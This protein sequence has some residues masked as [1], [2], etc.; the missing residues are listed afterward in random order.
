MAAG[1]HSSGTRQVPYMPMT[2]QAIPCPAPILQDD[3]DSCRIPG[4]VD[5][6]SNGGFYSPGECFVGYR[7]MCTQ[8]AAVSNGWPIQ[9][10]E[11]VVRCIPLTKSA[12]DSDSDADAYK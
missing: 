10:G 1:T 9:K 3:F 11:T 4:G 12:W 2:V 6:W 5:L 8:T 7:A